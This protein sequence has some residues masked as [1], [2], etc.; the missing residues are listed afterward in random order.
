MGK[1]MEEGS[2]VFTVTP[3]NYPGGAT[4]RIGKFFSQDNRC[5][6][7]NLNRSPPEC[8]VRSVVELMVQSDI[9][10]LINHPTQLSVC[11]FFV[12]SQDRNSGHYSMQNR[13]KLIIKING[14][15]KRHG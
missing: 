2:S 8:R 9:V 12:S 3:H 10:L 11:I 14:A 1:S 5:H 6:D 13:Y 4:E 7:Q 15:Q